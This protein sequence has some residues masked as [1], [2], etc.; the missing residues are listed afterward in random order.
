MKSVYRVKN[1]SPLSEESY[2]VIRLTSH[3]P[4]YARDV[5]LKS[6]APADLDSVGVRDEQLSLHVL[7]S[8][9]SKSQLFLAFEQRNCFKQQVTRIPLTGMHRKGLLLCTAGSARAPNFKLN[10][11][12]V[13]HRD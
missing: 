13:A 2:I 11:R 1:C 8:P 5:S 7:P 12:A 3:F 9:N 6:T 10:V 4:R